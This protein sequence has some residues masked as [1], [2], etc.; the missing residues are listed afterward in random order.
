MVM[1]RKELLSSPE[2]WIATLQIAVAQLLEK[3]IE[4]NKLNGKELATEFKIS[5]SYL[6]QLRAGDRNFTLS[7]MVGLAM[8]TGKVPLLF[9]VD[10]EET[11][12]NDR[13]G[14]KNELWLMPT[15]ENP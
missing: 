10:L 2:Y 12:E 14:L 8:A 9:F 7:T 13:L 3:Y 6:C 5:E 4:E 1:T 11:I 15:L